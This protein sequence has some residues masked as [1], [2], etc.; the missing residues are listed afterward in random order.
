MRIVLRWPFIILA[1]LVVAAGSTVAGLALSSDHHRTER[2]QDRDAA[3]GAKDAKDKDED[4]DKDADGGDKD[5]QGADEDEDDGGPSAPAEYLTQKF[6]SGHDVTPAQV[7][8]AEAQ[9]NA[10]PTGGGSWSLVGPSNIGGRI[11]DLVV[12]PRHPDTVYV[13]ASGGG[14]WKSTDAGLTFHAAWPDNL[15]QTL[16]ALAMGSDGTLWAGTGEANPSG[17]GL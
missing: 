7:R 4:R 5:G 6:T 10:L 11:T 14:V 9:A 8:R 16:G 17:G 1:V 12:D 13:A 2:S 15:T 3:G